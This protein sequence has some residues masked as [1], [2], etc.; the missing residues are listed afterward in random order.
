M[1]SMLPNHIY[2]GEGQR[3]LKQHGGNEAVYTSG[4]EAA[5]RTESPHYSLY[6][7]PYF[8]MTDGDK[9]AKHIYIGGERVA[10]RVAKLGANSSYVGNFEQ[11]SHA[12]NGLL[13]QGFSY[14]QLR[15]AQEGVIA[16]CY[17]SLG[18]SYSPV[19]CR[20]TK[21]IVMVPTGDKDGQHRSGNP[22]VEW[23]RDYFYC[24]DHLGS[25]RLV[26]DDSA[27]IAEKLMYLPTGEVFKDEQNS[28]YYHSDFLF[29][30]KELDAETGNY[31]Y[32]AR[33]LAPVLGIWLSPDP[34]QLK[35]PH[36]S[37]YAYCHGNPVSFVDM[38]G[39]YDTEAEAAK[40]ASGY[41]AHYYQDTQSGKWFVALNEYG[42]GA[43]I[44]GCIMT[45]DFGLKD[46]LTIKGRYDNGSSYIGLL[47]FDATGFGTSMMSIESDILKAS[48]STFRLINSKGYFDPHLYKNGWRGNRFLKTTKLASVGKVL[49]T[50]NN[51]TSAIF[52]VN[53]IEKGN[54]ANSFEES[55]D[56]YTDGL[57]GSIG[58]LPGGIPLSLFW[59]L[60]G[61]EASKIEV[62]R[63]MDYEIIG[64]PS[65]LPYK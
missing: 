32:G 36:V 48:K 64:L 1:T 57:I 21:D 56:N 65:V 49:G 50:A 18:Y 62:M 44:S 59:S 45:R 38:F 6:A 35:Y 58:M 39:L 55:I 30:G 53:S 7:N 43:Y 34:M 17:D 16:A 52:V 20:E 4:A 14:S 46:N 2:D 11:E 40:V 23:Q 5:V 26:L 27:H 54:K 41:H 28:S 3:A 13:P 47:D 12:G 31:Y 10:V 25:T 60:G 24:T 42:N 63:Q 22:D 37:S 29:S 15:Q 8:V 33:Y 51:I 19:S 61:K 9:Y